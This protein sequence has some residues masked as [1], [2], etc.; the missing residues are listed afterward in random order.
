MFVL[1]EIVPEPINCDYC[2][3]VIPRPHRTQKY[4]GEKCRSDANNERRA[5]ERKDKG[6]PIY[7][8]ICRQCGETFPT[9]CK[10]RVYCDDECKRLFR[11]TEDKKK[12]R[13]DIE[14]T[15]ENHTIDPYFLTGKQ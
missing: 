6:K 5:K 15:K 7:N 13:D 14:T 3:T 9:T 12:R 11:S 2:G 4:C 10:R 8:P 1:K